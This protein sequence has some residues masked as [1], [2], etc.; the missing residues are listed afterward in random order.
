MVSEAVIAEV[1]DA[2]E[3]F[4][5]ANNG[6]RGRETVREYLAHGADAV[7]VGRASDRPDVLARVRAATRE[8]FGRREVEA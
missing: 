2:T 4:V 1:V 7:S 8:W 5:I 6:V 3:L